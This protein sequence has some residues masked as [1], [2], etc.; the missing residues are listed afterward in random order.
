MGGG[1][2][3]SAAH[4]VL[5]AL[6]HRTALTMLARGVLRRKSHIAS[7]Q[8]MLV[9]PGIPDPVLYVSPCASIEHDACAA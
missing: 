1:S 6:E 5:E 4:P 9:W 2:G 8:W 7:R 3:L